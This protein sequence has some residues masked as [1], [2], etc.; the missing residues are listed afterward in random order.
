MALSE[1]SSNPLPLLKKAYILKGHD[2]DIGFKYASILY[3]KGFL[4]EAEMI[5]S[6]SSRKTPLSPGLLLPP[7]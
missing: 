7:L 3:S 5:V 2:L 4:E 6:S 1:V